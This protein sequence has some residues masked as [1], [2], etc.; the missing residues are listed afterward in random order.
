MFAKDLYAVVDALSEGITDSFTDI[1]YHVGRFQMASTAS[2]V[3]QALCLWSVK[4]SFLAFFRKLGNNVPHQRPIWWG[5]VLFNIASFGIWVGTVIWKCVAV[6]VD[7]AIATCN[8][9]TV[10]AFSQASIEVETA[11]DVLS[12]VASKAL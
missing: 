6:P 3:L 1:I 9:S 10:A 8:N 5:A 11:F 12:D 2:Y 7:V 4:A